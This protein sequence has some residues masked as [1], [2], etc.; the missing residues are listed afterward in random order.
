MEAPDSLRQRQAGQVRVAVLDAV[1]AA[2]ET[3]HF[4]DI[5]TADIAAAAGIS[6]RTLYRYFPDR[7][8]LLQAAGDH[9]YASLDIRV[10]ID[11]PDDI[12]PSL[13]D[14]GRRLGARPNLARALVRTPSGQAARVAIRQSR[15]DALHAATAP[16][17]EGLTAD[18]ARQASAVLTHL[19]SAA[20]WVT[21]ADE[22]GLSD[23]DAQLGAAW[24]IDTLV[25]A[26]RRGA[27]P[28]AR[29]GLPGPSASGR[30]GTDSEGTS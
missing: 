30:T 12:A 4:E 3:D 21:M 27:H 7:S 9:A 1:L 2:L 14:A 15:V 8:A 26:L 20:A 6:V 10:D 11:G 24:A 13:L 29:A 22:G 19:C 5:A 25:D 28:T 16:L 23:T 17:L 18:A